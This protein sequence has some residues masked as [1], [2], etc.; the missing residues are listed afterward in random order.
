MMKTKSIMLL[1]TYKCNLCCSYCY[2]SK[3]HG[4]KMSFETAKKAITEHIQSAD[5]CDFVEIQFMGGEPL[6]EFELIKNISEWFWSSEL[7]RKKSTMLFSPTNGTLLND[8]MKSWFKANKDRFCLGLSFDGNVSMQNRNRSNSASAVDLS[9]FN[10]NWPKQS[11]KMTI[12][13]ETVGS[14]SE[15]V[16]YLHNAGFNNVAADLAFGKD[17]KW[18]K[19]SLLQYKAEL[20]KLSDFYLNNEEFTPFSMLNVKLS[21]V[22]NKNVNRDKVCGCGETLVCIDWNGDKYACHL[23]SPISIS[24][25]KAKKGNELYNFCD[26][27]QFISKTCQSCLL[28]N[29][30][31]RCSGMSYLCTGDVSKTAPFHCSASKLIFAANYKFRWRLAER[32][33]D[34]N[35]LAV[36]KWIA[37]C[38]K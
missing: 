5:S 3:K 6:L 26:H 36:L 35:S 12:S 33:N 29:I 4:F 13:P 23:F 31:T 14:L 38:I 10:C 28:K 27:S 8:E 22:G 18:T 11:V 21:L 30:C 20:D 1:L 15:G 7:Y 9:F 32:N 37:R 34:N 17:I 25:D 19:E 24:L 2:E 16:I